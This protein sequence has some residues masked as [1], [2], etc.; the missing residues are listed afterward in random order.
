MSE[1]IQT[2]KAAA[3]DTSRIPLLVAAGLLLVLA[4]AQAAKDSGVTQSVAE[5]G[6][7]EST[8]TAY[9]NVLLIV[10]DDLG[11]NDTSLFNHGGAP[12]TPSLEAL[13]AD[14]VRFSRHYADSTCTPSR[15]SILTGRYAERM[16]FRQNGLE[17]PPEI[18]T[19]P[20][21]LQGA[22]YRTHLVGKWHAGEVRTESLPLAQGFDTFFGFHNQWEL[23]GPVTEATQGKRRPTYRNPMLRDG[24][25]ALEKREGHLTDIL[26]DRSRQ[27]IRE[28]SGSGTPWFLMHAFLA[29]HAP[30]EPAPRF[31][32][33]QRDTAEGRYLALVAHLDHVVGELLQTLR[34]TGQYDNTLVV[35]VSDNGGTNAARDNNYPW[36]G[37]KDETFEGSLRTPM[38]ML[39][40]EQKLAGEEVAWTVMN[41]DI[42]PTILGSVG[43]ALA[44]RN[45][46]DGQ[47]LIPALT[48]GNPRQGE[49]RTWEKYLS[50]VDAMNFSALSESG[51]WRLAN[52]YG[53][54]PELYDLAVTEAG[55]VPV[56]G[57]Y[58]RE[59]QALIE[60]FH[61]QSWRKSIVDVTSH[62]D[63][64]AGTTVYRG[65][66][67]NRTPYRHG[68]AIGLEMPPFEASH[69]DFEYAGQQGVWSLH[70]VG[71]AR[72]QLK[73][74]NMQLQMPEL[75]A[76]RCN[77]I[78]ITGHFQPAAM[79]IDSETSQNLKLYVNGALVDV[80]DSPR[81][82]PPSIASAS[83]PTVVRF[84]GRAHFSNLMLGSS[85]DPYVPVVPVEH[86]ALYHQKRDAGV[87]PRIDVS[88][89]REQLCQG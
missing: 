23:S 84:G 11:F 12:Q 46:L 65:A 63:D 55:D 71:S 57:Q 72:L 28:Q 59:Y 70:S 24:L 67:M 32:D 14:G 64:A 15:V 37:K 26:A 17:I 83:N 89:M 18:Q 85:A 30:I 88:R 5:F 29:P 10:A 38:V 58:P 60:Q 81:W 27:I 75:D 44:E 3:A 76:T 54:E 50:N 68:F 79:F 74:A 1:E 43:L 41:T 80:V 56:S 66:D 42:Y 77:D 53:L 78:V 21:V 22:G 20:E 33:Q 73:I 48:S 16:G 45:A 19:L 51:S 52:M 35:F 82:V 9:P 49:F 40:P 62:Q 87:L 39:L 7:R 13:A 36:Y 8:A 47:N 2:S 34:D 69:G 25:G 6:E 86:K 4:L 61:L 31:A